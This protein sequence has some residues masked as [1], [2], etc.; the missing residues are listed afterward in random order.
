MSNPNKIGGL[1]FDDCEICGQHAELRPYGPN[2]ENIC[3]PCG[4]RDMETTKK[5]FLE[6]IET[7]NKAYIESFSETKH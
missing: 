4:M 3:F 2:N 6:S 5:K 1:R 7:I